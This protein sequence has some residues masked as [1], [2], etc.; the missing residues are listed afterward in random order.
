MIRANTSLVKDYLDW[1]I[2]HSEKVATMWGVLNLAA[3]I[4]YILF[5]WKK[6]L[7]QSLLGKTKSLVKSAN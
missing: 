7:A 2:L 5:E 6:E 1:S 4:A 3:T